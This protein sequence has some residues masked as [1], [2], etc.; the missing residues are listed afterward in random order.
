MKIKQ[1]LYITNPI[2][3]REGDYGSCFALAG[4]K[5]EAGDKYCGDWINISK[6]QIDV[7]IDDET[8]VNKALESIDIVEQQI[9]SELQIKLNHLDEK[10]HSLLAIEHIK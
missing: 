8:V 1:Y 6:I 2:S 3:F 9:R 7:N 5:Y 4:R 10:R